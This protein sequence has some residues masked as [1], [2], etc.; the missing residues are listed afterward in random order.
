VDASATPLKP[1][2]QQFQPVEGPTDAVF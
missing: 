2:L 1:E